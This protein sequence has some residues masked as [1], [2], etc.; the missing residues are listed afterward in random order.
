MQEELE[1]YLADHNFELLRTNWIPQTSNLIG[2]IFIKD[3]YKQEPTIYMGIGYGID[4]AA[5]IMLIL[6]W[7][8]KM[9]LS[10]FQSMAK[11]PSSC[12]CE[13]CKCKIEKLEK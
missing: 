12:T 10:S 13:D 11:L 9:T 2:M 7:G 3:K 4:E 5:D 1:K 6:K 8:T